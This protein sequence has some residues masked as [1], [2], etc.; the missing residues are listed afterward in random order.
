MAWARAGRRFAVALVLETDGS[1]PRGPGARALVD[2]TGAILGTIGGGQVE[3]LAQAKAPAIARAGT[4]QIFEAALAGHRASEAEPICGGRMRVLLFAPDAAALEAMAAAAEGLARRQRGFLITALDDADPPRVE[5][6]YRPEGAAVPGLEAMLERAARREQPE[7]SA[8]ALPGRALLLEPL[9]P[10]PRLLVVGAGHVGQAV[11]RLAD[12]AGFEVTVLD[13]RPEFTAPA[14]FP[15][16][17]R[18]RCGDL[19]VALDQFPFGPDLYVVIVT[20]G[21]THDG[22]ALARCLGRPAAYVGMIGSVRKVALL[23]EDFLA[24]GRATAEEFDRVYAPIGLDL[25]AVTVPEI[26]VSVVA[27]LI[28]VRRRGVAPRMPRRTGP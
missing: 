12:L 22:A 17:V 2:E 4:A 19:A 8:H 15:P 23:R 18:T 5:L 24:R 13:D 9:V 28:A 16:A 25:G 3:A 27:Q 20:R 6:Q 1:S 11:A 14:L 26:A 7:F 21:H 10:P